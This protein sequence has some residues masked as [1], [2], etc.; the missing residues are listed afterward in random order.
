MYK[1]FIYSILALC[2]FAC[3]SQSEE[4]KTEKPEIDPL[5][6]EAR[7]DSL[8]LEY[9]YAQQSKIEIGVPV[10]AE[11]K[12]ARAGA[13]EDAADD[14]AIWIHPTDPSR[15][16]I[17]GS[18]KTGGLAVYNLK[19]EEVAYYPIGNANNVDVLYKYS[20]EEESITVLGC[21]NRS[22][23][24]I[25]LFR[26]NP[27]DGTLENIAAHSLQVDSSLIDDIYGFCF[28]TDAN[29]QHY[30]IINGKNGLMQ[31][32]ELMNNK[33]GVDMTLARAIQFPSQ[34]EGMVA[35]NE[36]GHLYVGEEA[37]GIWKLKITPTDTTRHLLKGSSTENPAIT[38]DVEGL[39]IYKVN[40]QEGYLLASIQGSFSYAV[41]DR[42]NGNPYLGSFKLIGHEQLDGVEETDGLDVVSVD[43]GA[44]FPKGVLVVQDG[45]NY[46]GDS[47]RAQ[48]FKLIDWREVKWESK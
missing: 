19:G 43:L 5:S 28:A 45:F 22:D 14:P 18:N 44:D 35:D 40:E 9:A 15:S 2:L 24:S 29:G 39:T 41:F 16:L 1:Y 34:T 47:L 25:D 27:S 31:Q 10:F 23:Q 4:K 30:A 12:A 11:T 42:N 21:S 13:E 6:T 20:F 3:Q 26:I 17:Y 8:A 33:A 7:E 36:L 32:F 37:G 38:Y 48:N 46:D